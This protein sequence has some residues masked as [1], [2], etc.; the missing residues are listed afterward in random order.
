MKMYK[1]V[2]LPLILTGLMVGCST[3][4]Q[5]RKSWSDPS[6]SKTNI[7][8]FTK[9]M[10]I[11]AFKNPVNKKLA[12]DKIAAAVKNGV[13]VQSYTYLTPADTVQTEV[14]E[15]LKNDGFDGVI[16][17][18]LKAVV[19]T[20]NPPPPGTSYVTFYTY[21]YGTT[22][23]YDTSYTPEQSVSNDQDFLV[24]TNIYSLESKMLLWSGVTAS[25]S[26]KKFDRAMDGII[27]TIK[28][29]LEK[30]GFIK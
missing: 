22:Y 25:I 8:P 24:E 29:A 30:K 28:L 26:P 23:R 9:V 1:K 20:H 13:A 27:N 21:S 15:K 18:R 11:V 4:T 19:K 16:M 7:K 2:L 3:T 14:V 5:I 6:L 10:V 17:M 12:E